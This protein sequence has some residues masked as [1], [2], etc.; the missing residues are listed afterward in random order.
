LQ[1]VFDDENPFISKLIE[2]ESSDMEGIIKKQECLKAVK[3]KT[4]NKSPGTDGFTGDYKVFLIDLGDFLVRSY[5]NSFH[6]GQLSIGRKQGTYS[7]IPKPGKPRDRLEI[8]RPI[9]LLNLTVDYKI[10]LQF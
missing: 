2:E 5:T 4:N 9:S 1:T 6:E 3:R 8:W 7:C 10:D